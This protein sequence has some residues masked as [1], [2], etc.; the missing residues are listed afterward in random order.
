[1]FVSINICAYR[2]KSFLACKTGQ[3]WLCLCED[4]MILFALQY[5]VN[6]SFQDMLMVMVM[7]VLMVTVV[8]V[9]MV[10]V[11]L[12]VTVVVMVVVW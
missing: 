4:V 8:L 3:L 2:K 11:V 1:M 7:V 12:M 6:V 5:V 10:M 9:V